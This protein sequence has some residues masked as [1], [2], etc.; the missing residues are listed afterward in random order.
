M[1]K[2]GKLLKT[3][4]N[5]IKLFKIFE[6]INNDIH[7]II[8]PVVSK[9]NDLNFDVDYVT[10]LEDGTPTSFTIK[11]IS[12][13]RLYHETDKDGNDIV[14]YRDRDSDKYNMLAIFDLLMDIRK[15]LH[16]FKAKFTFK[17]TETKLEGN[18]IRIKFER[19]LVHEICSMCEEI[20]LELHDL[21][22]TAA[23]F[24][25]HLVTEITNGETILHDTAK[26]FEIKIHGEHNLIIS[27]F[28]F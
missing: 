24:G 9:H 23:D 6:S 15:E 2:N 3:H 14:F 26:D 20:L 27:D 22:F 25:V 7:D 16:K 4:M 1:M 17:V 13:S 10:E 18:S 21:G 28:I 8:K 11:I 12:D 5:H 19:N